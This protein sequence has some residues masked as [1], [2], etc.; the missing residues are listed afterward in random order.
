MEDGFF[1]WRVN[2]FS[3]EGWKRYF[4]S[5]VK[6]IGG[7]LRI[8]RLVMGVNASTGGLLLDSKCMDF[9]CAC[10]VYFLVKRASCEGNWVFST[11][12]AE[13]CILRVAGFLG[14]ISGP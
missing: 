14:E 9:T 5:R 13:S 4:Y 10:N 12:H 3:T 7:A 8:Y 1:R 2:C 11:K 6:W